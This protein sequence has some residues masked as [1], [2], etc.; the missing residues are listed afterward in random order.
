MKHK[1]IN[2][3]LKWLAVTVLLIW[4]LL[5][6]YWSLRLAFSLPVEIAVFPPHF[7][8]ENPTPVSF[9]HNFRDA[10]YFSGW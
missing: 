2:Q 10:I 6:L 8:P 5:P 7:F 4:T 9:V 1:K 3:L